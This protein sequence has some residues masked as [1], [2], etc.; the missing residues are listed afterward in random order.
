MTEFAME[1]VRLLIVGLAFGFGLGASLVLLV[2]GLCSL[3]H[4]FLK[5]IGKE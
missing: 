5:I 1:A 3:F 4:T 2:E